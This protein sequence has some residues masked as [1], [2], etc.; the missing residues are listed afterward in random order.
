MATPTSAA[1]KPSFLPKQITLSSMPLLLSYIF[2]ESAA[3]MAVAAV[4][5]ADG[6]LP[7]NSSSIVL[8][9][10]TLKLGLSAFWLW[11]SGQES[12][13]PTT[14][15]PT[16]PPSAGLQELKR[17]TPGSFARFG[18]P[19]LLYAVNNNLFL[20]LL[21]LMP[22]AYLQLL[23]NSRVVWTGFAFR[24]LM[25]RHLS[26]Q[27]WIASVTLLLGC[28]ISQIPT[29]SSSSEAAATVSLLGVGLTMLYCFI[30][31]CAS[32]YS[33]MLLKSEPN[34]HVANIQ[35][36]TYGIVL[37]FLGLWYQSGGG[38]TFWRGWGSLSTWFICGCWVSVG[39]LISRVMKQFDNIIKIFC[40][41]CS[42]LVVYIASVF[43][44]AQSFDFLFIVA[45]VLVTTSG[46]KYATGAEK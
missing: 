33:E 24:W 13:L 23:L 36:Y 35:L 7:F 6:K 41:A 32:V 19:G 38:D 17:V 26:R 25:N 34:L 37:N 4:K 30:S 2:I 14:T 20:A 29:S 12:L 10:E 3:V 44:G 18:V 45:F 43:I 27:Q 42:N 11:Q 40:V 5:G 46:Y 9:T 22:P 21:T 1:S 28:V 15:T 39:L 31:V 16:T 8:A